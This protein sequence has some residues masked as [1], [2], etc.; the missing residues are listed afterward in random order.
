MYCYNFYG[1]GYE[2]KGKIVMEKLTHRVVIEPANN[3]FLVYI[4]QDIGHGTM[5]PIPYVFETM[6]NLLSFVERKLSSNEQRSI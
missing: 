4:N 3:G 5:R 2:L 1:R 6:A